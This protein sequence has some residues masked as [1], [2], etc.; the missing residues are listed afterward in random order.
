MCPTPCANRLRARAWPHAVVDAIEGVYD[1]P[2]TRRTSSPTVRGAELLA[3]SVGADGR[4]VDAVS[5]DALPVLSIAAGFDTG[6]VVIMSPVCKDGV[7]PTGVK[8]GQVLCADHAPA[9]ENISLTLEQNGRSTTTTTPG[10]VDGTVCQCAGVPVCTCS[11]AQG[12]LLNYANATA[13]IAVHYVD[14]TSSGTVT[15]P[16]SVV[17]SAWITANAIHKF[18]GIPAHA[19]GNT[20]GNSQVRGAAMVTPCAGADLSASHHCRLSLSSTLST[21]PRP[22]WRSSAS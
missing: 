17:P 14:G 11:L 8:T 2:G 9:I 10:T 18:Y 6:A 4:S 22:I 13:S 7:V 20:A 19:T 3:A 21:T 15:D 1:F 5:G 16:F 12:S